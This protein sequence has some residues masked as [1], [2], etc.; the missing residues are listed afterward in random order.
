MTQVFS[1]LVVGGG[2]ISLGN[3]F[4]AAT[5]RARTQRQPFG[6]H[7]VRYL[8]EDLQVLEELPG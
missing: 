7:T 6:C 8:P 1:L 2:S 4:R 3:N 5:L